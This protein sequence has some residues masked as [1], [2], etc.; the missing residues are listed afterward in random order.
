MGRPQDRDLA[1]FRAHLGFSNRDEEGRALLPN[2]FNLQ[3]IGRTLSTG[4]AKSPEIPILTSK[5][6]ST[7][8]NPARRCRE[9][10]QEQSDW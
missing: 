6:P 4:Y 9:R 1:T 2:G 3:R 10:R 7:T 5:L 8:F